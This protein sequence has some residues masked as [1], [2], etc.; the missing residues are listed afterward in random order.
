VAVHAQ[1]DVLVRQ[2]IRRSAAAGEVVAVYDQTGAPCCWCLV[3]AQAQNGD[4]CVG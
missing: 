4:W 1:S 2:L 3:G